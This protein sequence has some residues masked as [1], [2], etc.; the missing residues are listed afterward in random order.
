ME[1]SGQEMLF[2]RHLAARNLKHSGPRR[3]IL[4]AFLSS[5]RH[6]TAEE[7]YA[8]VKK[9]SPSVGFM[10]VYR[11]LKLIC[12]CGVG[13]VLHFEDGVARYE[14]L[15]GHRHHDH[16]VCVRCGRS[17]EVEDPGM[18]KLQEG[19]LRKAGFSVEGHRMD[20]YGLCGRC[21]KEAGKPG[22]RGRH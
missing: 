12:E 16:L 22:L 2:E 9:R 3:E 6:L 17:V 18:E 13:R 5:E 21:A 20:L 4:A 7:L 1:A 11:T 19:L 8:L 14:R 15:D 10:T